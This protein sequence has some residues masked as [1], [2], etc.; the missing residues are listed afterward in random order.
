MR[1]LMTAALH[2]AGVPETA[3]N[4][5]ES[6]I[7][8]HTLDAGELLIR[9]GEAAPNLYFV[10][11]GLVKM[12]YITDDGKEFVKSFLP[13]GSFAG[14][15]MAQMENGDSAFSV[16]CLEHTTVESAPFNQMQKLFDTVPEAMLFGMRFF[17]ALSLKKEKREFGFLCL[18][19]EKR[20][21]QFVADNQGLVDRITQADIARYLGITPVA[22]SRIKK[23]TRD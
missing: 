6:A 14:S 15:L 9:Q 5:L 11:S 18:S 7:K 1:F 2:Q 10:T 21:Q 3:L 16:V 22:L 8:Q 13:E 17:Q 12:Y 23:R 19:P 4:G 20:Y